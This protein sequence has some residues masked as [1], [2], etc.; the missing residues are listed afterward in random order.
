MGEVSRA[1]RR[2]QRIAPGHIP[3]LFDVLYTTKS[4]ALGLG[5]AISCRIAVAHRG[6]LWV[7]TREGDGATFRFSLPVV[8]EDS[9]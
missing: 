2:R 1:V 5:L 6:R 8:R 7:D 9:P 3:K 4:G